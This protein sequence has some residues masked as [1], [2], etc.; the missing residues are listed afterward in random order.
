MPLRNGSELYV[1]FHSCSI[2]CW[3]QPESA[4][5]LCMHAWEMWF[6]DSSCMHRYS[7]LNPHQSKQKCCT[8]TQQSESEEEIQ[9]CARQLCM[10]GGCGLLV[11]HACTGIVSRT[12]TEQAEV[13]H[14]HMHTERKQVIM[15]QN[16]KKTYEQI[17]FETVRLR[18]LHS[19]N[20]HHYSIKP[21]KC[22]IHNRCLCHATLN[23]NSIMYLLANLKPSN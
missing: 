10:H 16:N 18:N 8:C 22:L 7:V 5:Q 6:V 11:V 13:L 12:H 9:M 2:E 19:T 20:V 21:H 4:W 17:S 3:Q 15:T 23:H 14:M 1:A